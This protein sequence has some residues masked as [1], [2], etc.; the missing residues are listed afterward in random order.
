MKVDK[1][2]LL[3]LLISGINGELRKRIE[4]V[5]MVTTVDMAYSDYVKGLAGSNPQANTVATPATQAQVQAA[6]TST[7]ASTSRS[8]GLRGALSGLFSGLL[9]YF[10]GD[11]D[12]SSGGA[13][14]QPAVVATTPATAA[15]VA[16]SAA[17]IV[18]TAATV[19]SS[20]EDSG[21][22]LPF[23]WP[24]KSSTTSTGGLFTSTQSS[25]Q[26]ASGIDVDTD[27]DPTASGEDSAVIS[28]VIK[29][30]EMGGG[31]A[32]SPK[33]KS[34]QCKSA[35]QVAYD[36]KILQNFGIIRL[37]GVECSGVQ[38]VIN[39][40]SSSQTLFAGIWPIDSTNLQN[41]LSTLKTAVESTSRGWDA[42]HTISIGNELVNFGTATPN[43]IK[44]ALQIG[45]NWLKQNASGYSGP[46]VS[47]DTLVAVLANPE[48]CDL[49][50]YIAVNA[51][52]FWDG[53]VSPENSGS[54]LTSQIS[55]LK[56]V[57]NN[58]K[59]VLITESGW[60]T[61]GDNYGSCV[62][63]LSNQLKA[64]KS[65]GQTLGDQVL[66]FTTYND[67]WK[68]PGSSDVEQYWGIYGDPNA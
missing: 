57:C 16:S 14:T 58:G 36:M 39:S 32:Y 18:P 24:H 3:S 33:T 51:H 2:V 43:D 10:D 63:S 50:D 49:S 55:Q 9:D 45:R 35:S 38:N 12:T 59:D 34:G 4:Y 20:S 54:F 15:A 25:Y 66:M 21:W 31:I 6:A 61:K 47:V 11:D 29:Y 1:V 64:V 68:D 52:P 65:I 53:S 40:M 41:D 26:T 56:S 19:A 13:N 17:V 42:I 30:A 62:P 27:P 67:Y 22:I 23:T 7:P 60:P 5:T 44:T 37:Y 8:G 28:Q 46:V 48:L